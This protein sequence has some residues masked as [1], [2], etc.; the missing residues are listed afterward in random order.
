MGRK[1]SPP[2]TDRERNLPDMT[3]YVVP[4]ESYNKL[5]VT[6]TGGSV[7]MKT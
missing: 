4:S 7:K 3:S 1:T 6:K 2:K 5:S